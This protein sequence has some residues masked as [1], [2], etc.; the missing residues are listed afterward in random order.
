MVTT[1]QAAGGT[2]AEKRLGDYVLRRWL[3]QGGM[4][5]LYLATPTD[6]QRSKQIVVVKRVLPQFSQDKQFVRMFAREAQLAS[7]LKHPNIVEVFDSMGLDDEENVEPECFFAMEY[8]HGAD[9]SEVLKKLRE[10]GGTIP[11]ANALLIVMSM[12]NGL[13]RAHEHRDENGHLLGIVHRDVSPS[14]VM[15]GFGGEVKIT[16]F[17]VAKALALT[18]FTQAGT[19]KGKLSYMSP[20]QAVAD[21]VDR[22]TDIFAIGAVLFELTTMQRMFGGEN[23]LAVMHKLLFRERTRPSEVV[24]NYPPQLEKIVMKATA[25][26]PDERFASAKE[27]RSALEAFARASNIALSTDALGRFVASVIEAPPHPGADPDF[28]RP[29][30]DPVVPLP[31]REAGTRAEV[32]DPSGT[33]PGAGASPDEPTALEPSSSPGG[34]PV[35]PTVRVPAVPRGIAAT[36]APR[37]LPGAP[38]PGFDEP[39]ETEI[40]PPPSSEFGATVPSPAMPAPVP[41]PSSSVASAARKPRR[42]SGPSPWTFI[43]AGL[44]IAGS[45]VGGVMMMRSGT[46]AP[47]TAPASVPAKSSSPGAAQPGPA[48]PAAGQPNSQPAVMPPASATAGQPTP[49]DPGSDTSPAVGIPAPTGEPAPAVEPEPSAVEPEPDP[50]P[51]K[52]STTSKKKKKNRATTAPEKPEPEPDPEPEP[53]T[54][55]KRPPPPP[56]PDPAKKK[57]KKAPTDTLLPE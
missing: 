28:F 41:R 34:A 1:S 14:N 7:A 4:A 11:L 30:D 50:A 51:K 49:E 46:K 32:P 15:L 38:A 53:T 47:Q 12:C 8:V 55:I 13:H 20:E 44:V 33:T 45:A 57:K 43:L 52:S 25:R 27:M 5:E 17:G 35:R 22:R 56:P 31:G 16:D 26:E 6:P 3:A 23:E 18:S 9:L 21:P 37:H 39:A 2:S 54:P 19:R 48:Q 36:P 29:A 42:A 10:E 40:A 24:S